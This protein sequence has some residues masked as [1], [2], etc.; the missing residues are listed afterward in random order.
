MLWNKK[1]FLIA[2]LI[3]L[4]ILVS[5]C[6]PKILSG[7]AI[8]T[9]LLS[10]LPQS[11]YSEK[12]TQ[13]IHHINQ[14]LNERIVALVGSPN[15][16][17]SAQLAS[18]LVST[19]QNSHLFQRIDW[20]IDVQQN[21]LIHDIASLRLAGISEQSIDN[22][23]DFFTRRLQSITNPFTPHIVPI[24]KDWLGFSQQIIQKLSHHSYIELHPSTNTL[25]IHD[26]HYHWVLITAIP[27]ARGKA[28]LDEFNANEQWIKNNSGTLLLSGGPIYSAVGQTQGEQESSWMSLISVMAVITLLWFSFKTI[29]LLSLFIPIVF[30]FITGFLVCVLVFGQI[31][32]LTLV[33]STSLIG[34]VIDFPIHWLS[35]AWHEP[36]NAERSMQKTWKPFFVA[37]LTTL[38][39]YFMLCWTP[40]PILQESAVFSM[41][42]LITAFLFTY[43]VLPKYFRNWEPKRSNIQTIISSIQKT[44]HRFWQFFDAHRLASYLGIIAICLIF[45]PSFK[46][47]ISHWVH[48]PEYWLN[49][50]KLIAQKSGINPASQFFLI[51]APNETELLALDKQLSQSLDTLKTQGL[52]QNYTSLSQWV[53]SSP[54]QTQL[55]EKIKQLVQSPD[56]RL[57]SSIGIPDEVWK[58]EADDVLNLPTLS[59]NDTLKYEFA[60]RWKTLFLGQID[61][62]YASLITL[63]GVSPQAISSLKK[64]IDLNK[65]SDT[66]IEWVDYKQDINDVFHHARTQ[67]TIY[68]ILSL[69]LVLVVLCVCFGLRNGIKIIQVPIFASL[70]TIICLSVAS[71]PIG[72][73]SVFGLLLASAIGV[74]YAI[75]ALNSKSQSHGILLAFLTTFLTFILLA[76]SGTPAVAQFGL[77]VSI[78]VLW[79]MALAI[80]LS[81][82]LQR[83]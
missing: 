19:W 81:Y 24:D 18:K 57:L 27:I 66:S 42:T 73:F 50:S 44:I 36:W 4:A 25:Q 21:Q 26:G 14:P 70:L 59:I 43:F 37:L 10:L 2:Y 75:Y 45:P 72:I 31:H 8:D 33:I 29:R 76:F 51:T 1:I 79:N 22:A 62:Q 6:F 61:H 17:T 34:L 77:S 38:L 52:I 48:L 35:H 15:S 67:A 23:H 16:E 30:S 28:L 63:D 47:D 64:L 82:Q 5:L 69:I 39:G 13:A 53:N 68:K 55:R 56:A 54:T 60:Q 3:I 74:D 46:D 80:K 11:H 40:I 12:K 71:V 49:Q 41:A 83:L 7:Q 20:Q 9:N 32:I 78:G 58:K 65:R